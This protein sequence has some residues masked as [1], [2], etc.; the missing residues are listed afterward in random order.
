[1]GV[2]FDDAEGALEGHIVLFSC[3]KACLVPRTHSKPIA[4]DNAES[5]PPSPFPA[6]FADSGTPRHA[7]AA[8]RRPPRS[9]SSPREKE[10][11]GPVLRPIKSM[12]TTGTSSAQ[13]Q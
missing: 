2:G 3:Q 10:I 13:P 5:G 1:D 12:S 9:P 6:E 7:R 4:I 8:P 11:R